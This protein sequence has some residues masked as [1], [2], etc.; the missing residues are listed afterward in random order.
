M[1]SACVTWAKEQVVAFNVILLRQLSTTDRN[2]QRWKESMDQ[3]KR[4]AKML[5]EVG[6]DFDNIIGRDPAADNQR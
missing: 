6:L 4:H 2:D 3:A 5:S 1:M